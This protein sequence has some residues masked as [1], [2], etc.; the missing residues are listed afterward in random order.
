MGVFINNVATILPITVV[1]VVPD[2]KNSDGNFVE[3]IVKFTQGYQRY[4]QT[5]GV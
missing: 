1:D 2:T 5:A 3:F 4:Q